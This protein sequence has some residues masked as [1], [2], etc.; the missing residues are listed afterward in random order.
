MICTLC[1]HECG[2]QR[3]NER[4]N[5]RC[6]M[7]SQPRLARAALHFGEEPC[8]SGTNGSGTIFFSGCSLSCKF[9]QNHDI[10]H[11]DFGKTV[12]VS[13]LAD[14]FK[15]LEALGAHNINLVNPTHFAHVIRQALEQ[16]KPSV[17]VLYNSSGYEKIETLRALDGLIDIYLPDF[18]YADNTL[19]KMLSGIDRYRETALA[20]IAEMLR[21]TGHLRIENELAV[22]GTMIRH[23]V[24]PGHTQ[25]SLTVLNDIAAHFTTD[26]WVS[27]LFQYT[28]VLPLEEKELNRTLT[29]RECRKVFDAMCEAGFENGYAQDRSSADDTYIP[30]FDLTGI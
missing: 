29:P 2:G 28:P 14:I 15:E 25:N 6:R 16:Y 10:S 23:L 17:P 1:P 30:A 26:I 3:D 12:S 7:P 11:T 9:C 4:G 22:K 13:R 20:A 27:L 8:I 24:L 18:K 5:G 21:Q 19:A